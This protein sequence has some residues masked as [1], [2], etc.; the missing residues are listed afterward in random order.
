M[1]H[2][3][4]QRLQETS[5]VPSIDNPFHR[6]SVE[7]FLALETASEAAYTKACRAGYNL[8]HQ[9]TN[10]EPD[11][12]RCA[13]N[14]VLPLPGHFLNSSIVLNVVLP[15]EKMGNHYYNALHFPLAC[16]YRL[17]G[18]ARSLLKVLDIERDTPR[19]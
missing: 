13:E 8:A 10:S 3:F 16:S 7:T 11:I 4:I 17:D 18:E 12:L 6:Y 15:D 2:E 14:H 19:K 9:L 5:E 1:S